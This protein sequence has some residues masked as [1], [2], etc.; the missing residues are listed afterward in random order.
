MGFEDEY[1][2]MQITSWKEP[3]EQVNTMIMVQRKTDHV[4]THSRDT[5][6]YYVKR[7]RAC[8]YCL[9]GIPIKE[10]EDVKL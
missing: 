6:D 7:K 3:V 9:K 10:E 8:P 4:I 2:D 5:H 1:R